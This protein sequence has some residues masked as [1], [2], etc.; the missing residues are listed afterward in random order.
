MSDLLAGWRELRDLCGKH[1][2]AKTTSM[3]FEGVLIR[4]EGE[5]IDLDCGGAVV[6]I[7]FS[8]VAD[9]ARQR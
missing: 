2:I 8:H 5:E 9:I 7:A 1:V 4:V 3:S 6:R